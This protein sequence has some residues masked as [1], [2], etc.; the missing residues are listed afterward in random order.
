[1]SKTV[2]ITGASTG[3]GRETAKYFQEKGWNV[4]ATMRS[5]EKE[6]E[7]TKLHNVI[8]P[9]LDVTDEKS[10][11]LA[12]EKTFKEFGNIDVIVNNAGYS[13]TGV[14]EAATTA[15]LQHQYDVNVFGVMNVVRAILPYFRERKSGSIVNVSSVG[16]KMTLPLY[17]MYQSTKW[18]VSGF[19]E[20][21]HIHC[22]QLILPFWYVS[23]TDRRN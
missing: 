11:V 18:T 4:A 7:L 6:E 21:L 12:F 14:F 20:A 16:G 2:L 5:P 9:K 15:Q 19:S 17:S 23:L 10:I 13:L 1:M 8:C 22:S 3:I